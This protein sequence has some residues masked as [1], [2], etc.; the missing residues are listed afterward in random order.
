MDTMKNF[1]IFVSYVLGIFCFKLFF[2]YYGNPTSRVTVFI[3]YATGIVMFYG[4]IRF[5]LTK[6]QPSS[7]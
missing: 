4:L 6:K 7:K 5:L 1:N 2:Y 3:C